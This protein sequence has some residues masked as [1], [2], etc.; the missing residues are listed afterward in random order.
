MDGREVATL[1]VIE[2]GSPPTFY[3]DQLRNIVEFKRHEAVLQIGTFS[4]PARIEDVASLTLERGDVEALRGCRPRDCDVQLSGEAI[5]RFRNR[6]NWRVADAAE[7]ANRV[8]R[9]LLAELANAYRE[10]GDAGLMSYEDTSR[11]LSVAQEFRAMIAA[12]P[13]V[14]ERFPA[15]YRHVTQ[16]PRSSV[17]DVDDVIYWSKEKLG[18]KVIV[19]VTHLA[20][21][22][23]DDSAPAT[24]G[25]ASKQIYA[26]HYFDSSLGLTLLLNEDASPSAPT[27]MVYVNRSRLDAL[28]GFFGGLKRAVVRSRTRSATEASLVEARNIVERRF[29][30]RRTAARSPKWNPILATAMWAPSTKPYR[31]DRWHPRCRDDRAH[32]IQ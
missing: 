14:L 7:Q 16:F 11:T 24:Y 17:G 2:I 15:L 20:I 29:S 32:I 9:E 23:L 27:Y 3:V 1:G 13:A 18:P 10:H 6:V 22:R 19:T 26:T 31:I 4:T 5:D 25:V 28:G 30:V 12:R 8:M 21:V